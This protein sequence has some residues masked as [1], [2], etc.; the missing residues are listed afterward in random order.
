MFRGKSEDLPH[1][2][3]TGKLLKNIVRIRHPRFKCQYKL[4]AEILPEKPHLFSK[5]GSQPDAHLFLHPLL[6]YAGTEGGELPVLCSAGSREGR[7][8]AEVPEPFPHTYLHGCRIEERDLVTGGARLPASACTSIPVL[9]VLGRLWLPVPCHALVPEHPLVLVHRND[10]TLLPIAQRKV[11]HSLIHPT[12]NNTR[13][14][15]EE[16]RNRKKHSS[17]YS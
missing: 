6:R 9:Q 10:G 14:W 5:S 4:K 15:P 11:F 17:Y 7:R 2:K 1:L 8:L 13:V 3:T 12:L 16:T